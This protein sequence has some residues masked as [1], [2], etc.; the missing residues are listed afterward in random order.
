MRWENTYKTLMDYGVALRDQYKSNLES[1]NRR[2]TGDLLDSIE[3]GIEVGEREWT[4]Y[5]DLAEYWKYVEYDTAPHFPPLDKI[6]DWIKAK[7]IK[8]LPD[9]R[10][11]VPTDD[12]LAFLIGRAMAGLSPN[13]ANCKNPQGGTTGTHDLTD[14]QDTVFEHFQDALAQAVLDDVAGDIGAFM[15]EFFPKL[16]EE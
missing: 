8:A 10:G 1:N 11:R 4:V 13:Q 6:K 3:V 14:A 7:P 12:Q 16:P 5:L 9:G 2:A 15:V